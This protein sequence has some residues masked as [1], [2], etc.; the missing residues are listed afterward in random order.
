MDRTIRIYID[1]YEPGLAWDSQEPDY[2]SSGP[3][4]PGLTDE[5]E[6]RDALDALWERLTMECPG[7]VA[8]AWDGDNRT[9][10]LTGGAE[11]IDEA[12][13]LIDAR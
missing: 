11:A 4:G 12:M 7:D 5:M 1:C 13:A 6:A 8:A 9:I 2:I 3:V 10:T